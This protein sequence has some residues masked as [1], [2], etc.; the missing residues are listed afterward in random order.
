VF[1]ATQSAAPQDA[2]HDP[3]PT[4]RRL[5]CCGCC[6]LALLRPVGAAAQGAAPKGEA[7]LAPLPRTDQAPV[8]DW[9]Q[10][11]L[12]DRRTLRLKRGSEEVAATY[13]TADRGW[14]RDEYYAL[15]WIMRDLKADRVF[16]IDRKLLD[17]LCGVQA[18]LAYNGQVAPI[19]INSAYRTLA[20]NRA[21]EGSARDSKHVVGKAAD[22][23]VDGVS[24][25]KLA[26]MAS[27]FGRGG[28]GFYVGRG[29]VHVDTGDERIWIQQRKP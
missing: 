13:W 21:T 5:L 18:W 3:T 14:N 17:V 7:P 26:V 9:R 29:F 1:V 22:I 10:L 24:S 2:T 16:P 20:T 4:R 12:Q 27:E 8:R 19:R 28:T 23:V 11:L 6:A 25:V 15:C